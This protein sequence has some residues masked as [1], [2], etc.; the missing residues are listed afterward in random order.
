M[1][2]R[3]YNQLIESLQEYE[4]FSKANLRLKTRSKA[5]RPDR[6]DLRPDRPDLRGWI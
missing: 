3:C 5:I 1:L 4:G 2:M 6:P